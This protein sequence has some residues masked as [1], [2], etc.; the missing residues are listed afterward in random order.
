MIS[1]P[2][3]LLTFRDSIFFSISSREMSISQSLFHGKKGSIRGGSVALESST[4]D[5]EQKYSLK[6]VALSESLS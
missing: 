6:T 4:V 1:G 3:A 2:V 5:C